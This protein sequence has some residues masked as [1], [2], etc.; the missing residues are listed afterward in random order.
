MYSFLVLGLIPG[1]NIEISFWA[2]LVLMAGLLI[3]FK[4]YRKRVMKLIADWWRSL[5]EIDE[6]D[7]MHASRFHR[8]LNLTAR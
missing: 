6:L 4:L 8:R 5:D 7:P 3:A 1:T 2:W